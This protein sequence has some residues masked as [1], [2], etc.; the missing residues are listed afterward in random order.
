MYQSILF[1]RFGSVRILPVSAVFTRKKKRGRKH[2]AKHQT[3]T[4]GALQIRVPTWMIFN[5]KWNNKCVQ[6]NQKLNPKSTKLSQ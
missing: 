6:N 3:I 4:R 2:I 5:A 1:V